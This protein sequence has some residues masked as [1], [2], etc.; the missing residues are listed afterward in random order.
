MAELE[1]ISLEL[2]EEDSVVIVVV[3]LGG[4]VDG[5]SSEVLETKENLQEVH[6]RAMTGSNV[7][8]F[9][10]VIIGQKHTHVRLFA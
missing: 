8:H 10:D 6:N 7:F 1:E 4:V 9:M 5:V 2:D 3:T